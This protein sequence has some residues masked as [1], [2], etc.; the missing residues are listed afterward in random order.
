M[1]TVV[2]D[3]DEP[4][5]IGGIA[6]N[7]ERVTIWMEWNKEAQKYPIALIKA[8]LSSIKEAHANGYHLL[9][10][11]AKGTKAERFLKTLGMVPVNNSP[12]GVVYKCHG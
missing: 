12:D 10:A 2:N 11:V 5:S 9:Y 7:K 4:I 8:G 3:D 6:F 1:R